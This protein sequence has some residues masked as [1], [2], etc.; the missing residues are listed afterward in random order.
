MQ[1]EA[2]EARPAPAAKRREKEEGIRS[3]ERLLLTWLIEE[4]RLFDVIH[5]II[6]PEDFVKPLFRAAAEAV[7]ESREAGE[8]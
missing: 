4:P 1:E 2:R 6:G 5:G 8:V 7:F 3:S